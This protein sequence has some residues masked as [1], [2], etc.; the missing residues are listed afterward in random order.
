MLDAYDFDAVSAVVSRQIGNDCIY[1]KFPDEAAG[2]EA[3]ERLL[4]GQEI[5]DIPAVN[6]RD[7]KTAR[8]TSSDTGT[9]CVWLMP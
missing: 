1:L 2:E 3:L 7:M 9:V 8:G 6:E 5:F 4:K